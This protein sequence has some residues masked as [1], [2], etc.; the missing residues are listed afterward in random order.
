VHV[1]GVDCAHAAKT[2]DRDFEF[3]GHKISKNTTAGFLRKPSR[4]RVASQHP[5]SSRGS[6]LEFVQVAVVLGL[7]VT[8]LFV[9]ELGRWRRSTH[10]RNSFDVPSARPRSEPQPKWTQQAIGMEHREPERTKLGG[11]LTARGGT[12]SILITGL[13]PVDKHLG[14]RKEVRTPASIR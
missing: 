13:R 10:P 4:A 2:R 8:E 3:F 1:K 5:T 9:T 12:Q 6:N 14:E 7:F 11:S